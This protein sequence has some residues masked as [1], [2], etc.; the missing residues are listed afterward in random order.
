MG[1]TVLFFQGLKADLPR[2]GITSNGRVI[3]VV[4]ERSLHIFDQVTGVS[5]YKLSCDFFLDSQVWSSGEQEA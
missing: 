1:V 3:A 5:F 4:D 2:N